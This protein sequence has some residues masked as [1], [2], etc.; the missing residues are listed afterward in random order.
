MTN[1][2]WKNSR[3]P[4]KNQMKKKGKGKNLFGIKQG[5]GA[6]NACPFPGSKK[7]KSKGGGPNGSLGW[8][9]HA[10]NAM[11]PS[12][13]ALPRAVGGYSVI[14]TTDIHTISEPFALF[15][16]FKGPRTQ[17]TE[18]CWGTATGVVP[19][20]PGYD[21]PIRDE[22][23]AVFLLSTPLRSVALDGTTMVPA[24][25]TVQIMNGNALQTTSGM[26]FIGRSKTVLDL[27]GDLR[28]WQEVADGLINYSAPRLCSAGK[29][30]LRGV[31][32]DG[33][34][35][36]MSVLSDFVPRA[37][38]PGTGDRQTGTWSTNT[39]NIQT[40][41]AGFGPI[42][43]VNPGLVELQV[44]V[45]VEWRMRFDPLNPAYAGHVVHTPSSE[46]TWSKVI[47]S[48]ESL[49]NGVRDIADVVADLGLMAA[50]AA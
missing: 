43:V 37:N 23:N 13:L 48:A 6:V 22:D 2:S 25:I 33:V 42:F 27:M 28:T 30:A 44:I 40:D 29:L 39:G 36:N 47:S 12:H 49:G 34:P 4:M 19:G 1:W 18:T 16:L 26:T 24:A 46:S 10:L 20:L 35:N 9:K 8:M 15:G 31:Q 21:K 17:F 11:H 38:F 41:F 3:K 50:V 45:T 32:V 7:K 14:R 5:A